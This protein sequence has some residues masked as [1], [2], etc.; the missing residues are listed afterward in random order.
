MDNDNST[1]NGG[2]ANMNLTGKELERRDMQQ[3]RE[4]ILRKEGVTIL[5]STRERKKAKT[6]GKELVVKGGPDIGSV[7]SAAID[8]AKDLRDLSRFKRYVVWI[9]AHTTLPERVY[10]G[11]RSMGIPLTMSD[12]DA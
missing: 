3:E 7:I 10:S 9:E 6:D 8:A 11:L 4:S 2:I 5:S 1:D 12:S